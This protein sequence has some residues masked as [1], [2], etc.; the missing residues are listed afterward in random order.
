VA[1]T[2][3][4]TLPPDVSWDIHREDPKQ[5]FLSD[6][7]ATYFFATYVDIW[8]PQAS[9][10]RP[11]LPVRF[12][13]TAS[14]EEHAAEYVPST[15]RASF[16][17]D[18]GAYSIVGPPTVSLETVRSVVC[19]TRH[20]ITP[21]ACAYVDQIYPLLVDANI[22]PAIWLVFAA[23]E[24]EYGTTGPGR[25]PPGGV[26]NLHNL[27]PNAWDGG[28][29]S[30]PRWG[31]NGFS[32]Y[33]GYGQ[34]I[35][36][37][38]ELMCCRGLYIDAGNV[39]P[40]QI[41]S[42]YAPSFENDT[43][44]YIQQVKNWVDGWRARDGGAA[45]FQP[46]EPRPTSMPPG[47]PTPTPD[48]SLPTPTP[49]PF[50]GYFPFASIDRLPDDARAEGLSQASQGISRFV[51][52]V[53]LT[54]LGV[55]EPVMHL[56]FT[57]ALITTW[58]TML[59]LTPLAVFT[60]TR[61]VWTETLW[62]LFAV[63]KTSWLASLWVALVVFLLEMVATNGLLLV[64]MSFVGF[65]ALIWGNST[66]LNLLFAGTLKDGIRAV[67]AIGTVALNVTLDV[68]TS[69]VGSKIKDAVINVAKDVGGGKK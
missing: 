49:D 31:P 60:P 54:L 44:L 11:R 7:A 65:V 52:G 15:F 56:L 28:G 20:G 68:A 8:C 24:T 51:F 64:G 55:A 33:S 47:T 21:P 61:Q 58:L 36:A 34:S 12:A 4:R 39:T 10:G 48:P 14:V 2:E 3:T 45:N 43:A 57:T 9:E 26:Y 1:V 35:S 25:P 67:K 16:D 19:Q 46:R 17:G 13:G 30:L 6:Y 53:G 41:V 42:I 59:L 63:L 50:P 5:V 66:A 32:V 40:A 62:H 38:I 27:R 69:G 37:W 23:K 29:S 18:G 22:D